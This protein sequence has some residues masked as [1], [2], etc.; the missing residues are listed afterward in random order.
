MRRNEHGNVFYYILIAVALLAALSF[1]IAQGGRSS[2]GTLNSDRIGLLATDVIAYGDTVGKAVSQL[3][4]RGTALTELSFASTFLSAAEYGV[5]GADAANEIF[6]PD[7]GAVVY[8]D[9]PEDVTVS[10]TETYQFLSANEVENVGTTCGAA[11]CSDLIVIVS[12]VRE[13]ICTRINDLLGVDNPSDA[14][15]TD[16]NIDKTV[17]F[18]PAASP[19]SYSKTLG[20][21][22]AALDGQSEGC[23][24]DTT[25]TDYV[26]Y[27]V[28]LPR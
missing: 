8:Q 5:Y 6:N 3:R 19:F 26:Y 16:T 18:K 22:D 7:G 1:A 14:P 13:D 9:P 20:D 21:E 4:L 15:P 2:V 10:G 12:G 28:L 11:A 24:Q 25:D 27:K 17:P 23:F